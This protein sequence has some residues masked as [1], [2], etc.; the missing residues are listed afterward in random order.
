MESMTPFGNTPIRNFRDGEFPQVTKITAGAIKDTVRIGMEAC[1]GC[2]VRCKKVVKVDEPGCQVD[3]A[4]GGPEYET[5]AALGSCCGIDDLK[6]ICKGN[7]L[8]AAYSLDTISTGVTI[9]FAMEC[10]ENGLLTNKDTNGL[11]LR[12]GNAEAMLKAIELIA[13]REGIGDLLAEGSKRAAA[14]IGRG[15]EKF[16]IQ[17]KGQEVPMHDPRCK[18]ALGLGYTVDPQGADHCMSVQDTMFMAPGPNVNNLHPMG[19][20]EPL[21]PDDLSPKKVTLFRYAHDGRVLAD[22]LTVCYFVPFSPEQLTDM[23]KA[24]TGWDTGMVELLK[25]A[26]RTLTLFRMFNLREGFTAADDKLPERFFEGRVGGAAAHKRYDHQK[27]EWAKS[28]WYR[29]MGWDANGVPNPETL[30]ALGID[31]AAGK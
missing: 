7:E 6:A 2:V 15:A 14:K 20:L 3:P 30:E 1:Y 12:F 5:L 17:V 8:C 19:V 18:A 21:P 29:L 16:S 23:L 13:H 4:Y 27:L 26:E 11:E 25:T 22:S 9:S 24:V 10:F 28:Y 31:W